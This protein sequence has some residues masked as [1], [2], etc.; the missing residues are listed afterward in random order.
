MEIEPTTITL[1]RNGPPPLKRADILVIDCFS[2]LVIYL[3]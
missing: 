3:L 1:P 2:L